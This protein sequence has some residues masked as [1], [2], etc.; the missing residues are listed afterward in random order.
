MP[1]KYEI[2]VGEKTTESA[3]RI[4]EGQ[5]KGVVLKYGKVGFH[6]LEEE[7]RLYF[8]YFLIK[9][10]DLVKDEDHFKEVAGDIL[11]DLLENHLDEGVINGNDGNDN[12]EE[13]DS[14]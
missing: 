9:E 5:Y 13:S 8:D 4:E 7:C 1:V 14:Q 6:E 3:V 2:V 10:S 12:F 11:V